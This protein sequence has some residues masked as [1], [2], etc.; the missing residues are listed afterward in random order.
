MEVAMAKVMG[1][2]ALGFCESE[3]V[4]RHHPQA[5]AAA[6]QWQRGEAF[7]LQAPRG[8]KEQGLTQSEPATASHPRCVPPVSVRLLS[9]AHRPIA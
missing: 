5:R 6:Q 3:R 9:C 8:A 1:H 4:C 7:E 2:V